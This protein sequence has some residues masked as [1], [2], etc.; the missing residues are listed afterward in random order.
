MVNQLFLALDPP[1]C[2]LTDL[3]RVEP[4]PPLGIEDLVDLKDKNWIHKVNEG[5]AHVALV[6]EVDRQVE[7]VIGAFVGLVDLLEEHLLGVFVRDILNHNR[8]SLV[9]TLSYIS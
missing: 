1:I 7:E 4:L 2:D 9:L 3:L 8:G 6:L 5:I